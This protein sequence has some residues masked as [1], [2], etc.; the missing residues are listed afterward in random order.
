MEI[1]TRKDKSLC[2][3]TRCPNRAV[4]WAVML[5]QDCP[6]REAPF[7]SVGLC[8]KHVEILKKA[9]KKERESAQRFMLPPFEL[10]AAKKLLKDAGCR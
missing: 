8:K 2:Q 9:Q 1:D 4:V 7:I 10:E 5:R 3:V 6:V